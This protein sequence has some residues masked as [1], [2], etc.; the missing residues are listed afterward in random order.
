MK[1]KV[2]IRTNYHQ[3]AF[4]EGDE[5]Y[6]DGYVRGGNDVPL[7]A[8]VCNKMIDLVEIHNLIVL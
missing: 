2:K 7:A 8:V 1:T 3:G 6:I 5:G 4:K